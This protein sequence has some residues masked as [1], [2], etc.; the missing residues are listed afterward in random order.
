MKLLFNLFINFFLGSATCSGNSQS[1]QVSSQISTMNDI[2]YYINSY[3]IASLSFAIDYQCSV[4]L[5]LVPLTV[6]HGSLTTNALY[7]ILNEWLLEGDV[8][9]NGFFTGFLFP[10]VNSLEM[11][12]LV[13][14]VIAN[15]YVLFL[16][17]AVQSSAI[18]G[19]LYLERTDI[20]IPNGPYF[21]SSN[22]TH[23]NFYQVYRLYRDYTN[24]FMYGIVPIVNGVYETLYA[25]ILND[26]TPTIA[27]PSRLYYTITEQQPLAGIRVTV[28]DIYDVI[29]TKTGGGNLAYFELYPVVNKTAFSVQRLIDQGA[30]LVGKVKTAQFANSEMATADWVDY[31]C[32]FNPRGDG[33]QQPQASSSGS[34]ASTAAYSW[35][36]LAIGTDTGGSVR[37]PAARQGLYG[38]R[39]S[40]GAISLDGVIQLCSV[41]DTAGFVVRDATLLHTFD[42]AWY[43]DRFISYLKFPT[44]ILY[45]TEFLSQS[46]LVMEIFQNFTTQLLNFLRSNETILFNISST[47][48]VSNITN[49]NLNVYYNETFIALIG[50]YQYYNLG[51]NF[52]NDYKTAYNER[53]PF[54]NPIPMVRW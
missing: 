25:S 23:I 21:I 13:N 14:N 17:N 18:D 39:P 38:I 31:Q 11:S 36:D 27:V 15:A 53:T 48:E 40:H 24:S 1:M 8:I 34:A 4:Q 7:T 9:S 28:K 12:L 47:F 32:P 46:S 5:D 35:L 51:I 33:Y 49:T 2:D 43:N 20:T 41:L 52:I 3:P 44:K 26:N 10:G 29:G 6:I 42:K 50:H 54:I 16:S 45:S 37:Q 30:I 22:C 19:V